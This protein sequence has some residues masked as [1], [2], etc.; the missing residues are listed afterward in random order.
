M[1]NFTNAKT[2]IINL[3]P[4]Y[5]DKNHFPEKQITS[6]IAHKISEQTGLP[7]KHIWSGDTIEW[8]DYVLNW[9]NIDGKWFYFKWAKGLKSIINELM[10]EVISKYF[11]LESAHYILA[12]LDHKEGVIS[13]NFCC[14]DFSYKTS[15]ELKFT[16][17]INL[18]ILNKIKDNPNL[19]NSELL[20]E[21]I[22]KLFIR[23]FYTIQ[24]DRNNNN[25]LFKCQKNSIRM[26]PLFDYEMAF[27]PYTNFHCYR[28][29]LGTLYLDFI[30]T[31]QLVINDDF[32]QKLL[33]LLMDARMPLFIQEVED[34][35]EIIIPK[36][37]KETYLQSDL[38][39][40]KYIKNIKVIR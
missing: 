29:V 14:K 22:K 40:K 25:L 3:Q 2:K 4:N 28:N 37:I 12:K 20:L 32:F 21:D 11:N 18:D 27:D 19:P 33:L 5:F 10:G 17:Q 30:E 26:A 35:N 7:L 36:H 13:Q 8:F 6:A 23:D 39:V 15:R 24:N 34:I 38:L 16:G 1:Q 9:Y 31:R